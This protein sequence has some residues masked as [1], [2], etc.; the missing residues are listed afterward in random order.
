MGGEG[1]LATGCAVCASR[2]VV[3][4]QDTKRVM[5]KTGGAEVV[6]EVN[7]AVADLPRAR[8]PRRKLG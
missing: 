3:C 5:A 1:G 4:A 7:A 2:R 8:G 6:R